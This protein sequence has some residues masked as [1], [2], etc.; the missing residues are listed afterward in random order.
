MAKD[1]R[2]N[3][4]INEKWILYSVCI[5]CSAAVIILQVEEVKG[6]GKVLPRTGYEEP[7][8]E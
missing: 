3:P 2:W 1:K 5:M 6:K 4:N 7:E 8:G